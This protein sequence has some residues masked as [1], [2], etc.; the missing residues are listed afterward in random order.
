MENV[1]NNKKCAYDYYVTKNMTCA[2]ISHE[3][4][5]G[6][7]M[8]YKYIRKH[9]LTKTQA[10]QKM[11]KDSLLLVNNYHFIYHFYVTLQYT[12]RNIA[13][14]LGVGKRT[15]T[16]AIHGF[17]IPMRYSYKYQT[18]NDKL[19]KEN[20]MKL[21]VQDELSLDIIGEKCGVSRMT[22]QRRL[23]KYG[24]PIRKPTDTLKISGVH[25]DK[26]IPLLEKHGIKHITSHMM[27]V[28]TTSRTFYY[29]ID[30][31]LPELKI[32]IE[33]QGT[34]WHGY[35]QR[36]AGAEREKSIKKN[37]ARDKRKRK[38]L[39]DNFPD[40]KLV[41]VLDTDFENDMAD[42]IISK[43][44]SDEDIKLRLPQES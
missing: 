28:I 13:S 3:L 31:Y 14:F 8:V 38:Y 40:H 37:M 25:K 20:L 19:S 29:E 41:Y 11:D 36:D 35:I 34:Y 43:I 15:I 12:T 44:A 22:I 27:E 1:L 18:Y 24:V 32:F 42:D 9:G 26:L 7:H 21:Y 6:S 5:I 17:N 2:E 23:K 4:G 39:I 33:L 10:E 16:K 30:E